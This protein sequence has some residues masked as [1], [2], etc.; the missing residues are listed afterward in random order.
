MTGLLSR[1]TQK[2]DTVGTMAR[3]G[4]TAAEGT[5]TC[6]IPHLRV[7]GIFVVWAWSGATTKA[8]AKAAVHAVLRTILIVS[9]LRPG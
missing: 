1:F 6:P 2:P 7:L 8:A 4:S 3:C 9:I 5:S